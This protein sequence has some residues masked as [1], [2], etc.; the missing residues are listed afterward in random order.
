[1]RLS[2]LFAL[3][4]FCAGAAAQ[5]ADPDALKRRAQDG[6]AAAMVQLGDAYLHADYGLD[7]NYYAAFDWLEKAATLNNAEAMKLLAGMYREGRGMANDPAKARAWLRRA[8][9]LG[10][11]EAMVI[12]GGML[13]E[14]EG[15]AADASGAFALFDAAAR[16]GDPDGFFELGQ[17]Y[18]FGA[19]SGRDIAT[20]TGW[21][22]KAEAAGVCRAR[23]ALG[24]LARDAAKPDYHAAEGWFL[25]GVDCQDGDAMAN[26][27]LMYL[28]GQGV[29]PDEAVATRWLVRG[30]HA[31]SST[32]SR[33]LRELYAAQ[34]AK[35]QF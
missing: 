17:A 25:R 15:G 33:L 35:T 13:A 9:D 7:Q 28:H 30:S 31:G 8:A 20:A 5:D 3:L 10:D 16:A 21:F 12:L 18:R 1:M 6:D 2:A 29:A 11:S 26:L 32:A 14:G 22:V 27:G 19:A 34:K 23:N 24:E 4:V